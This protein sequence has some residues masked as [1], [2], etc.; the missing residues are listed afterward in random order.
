MRPL[1]LALSLAVACTS[2]SPSL[3][4]EA[5]GGACP[6]NVCPAGSQC[7]VIGGF[8]SG[9]GGPVCVKGDSPCDALDCDGLGC[10]IDESYPPGVHCE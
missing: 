8:A 1:L 7:A 4:Q 3:R 6:D 2:E 5:L 10:A 9:P